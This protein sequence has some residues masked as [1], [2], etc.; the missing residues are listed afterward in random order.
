MK[1]S[2]VLAGF[3][4]VAAGAAQTPD[5]QPS[6]PLFGRVVNALTH[7]PLRLTSVKIYNSKEQ[8]DEL[9]DKEGRF[10]FPPLKRAE[11]SF[12]AHREGF[13]DRFYKVELSDFDDPKDLAVELFPQGVITGKVVDGSGQPLENASITATRTSQRANDLNGSVTADTNDLG[14]YRLSGLD[15][16]VYQVRAAYRDGRR[17]EF[18]PTPLTRASAVYGVASKPTELTVK[19][20][21]VIER[22]DLVLNPA[23][24]VRVRGTLHTES[25]QPVIGRVILWIEGPSPTRD[26]SHNGQ[27]EDGKF[28][29][30]EVS[31]G[32][33]K[34]SADTGER[35]PSLFGEVSV[36]VRGE[37]VNGVDLVMHPNPEIDG[38]VQ[39]REEDATR[40]ADIQ[41]MFSPSDNRNDR[42]L[43]IRMVHVNA[44]GTFKTG[45]RPGA[46][47][48]VLMPLGTNL[49]IEKITLD[50]VDVPSQALRIDAS[51]KPKTLTITL[52]PK[53]QP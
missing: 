16:G 9:S 1:L 50:D 45:L 4:L 2:V 40:L 49:A 18:D 38:Q 34:I 41:V 15:P 5:P 10:K 3:A 44:A 7:E 33:Y 25:G 47:R 21:V 24:P 37:N 53:K 14:E 48:L 30:G 13:T 20:G 29:I 12:G 22:I 43:S 35:T 39:V 26:G 42:I 46:Y 8:W 27:G 23:L 32:T 51:A 17:S 31:P 36:E 19:P 11:Y 52:G 28:E 6:V